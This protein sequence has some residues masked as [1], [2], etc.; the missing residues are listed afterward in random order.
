MKNALIGELINDY[1]LKLISKVMQ[2]LKL[3]KQYRQEREETDSLM[4]KAVQEISIKKFFCGW[5]SLAG[6]RL[7]LLMFAE[8][9]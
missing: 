6:K 2:A 9:F 8:T 5:R 3:N 1:R 4:T 7:G